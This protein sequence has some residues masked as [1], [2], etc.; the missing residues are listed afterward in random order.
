M[1][2]VKGYQLSQ[3]V[4][5]RCVMYWM[6]HDQARF[7]PDGSLV[8]ILPYYKAKCAKWPSLTYDTVEWKQLEGRD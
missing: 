1:W 4:N 3:E 8:K 6:T 7:A 2:Q 5:C